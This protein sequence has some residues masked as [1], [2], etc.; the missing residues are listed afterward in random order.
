MSGFAKGFEDLIKVKQRKRGEGTER[1]RD[2]ETE[3]EGRLQR[4]AR[5]FRERRGAH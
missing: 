3:E 2:R 5:E 1:Q 4:L